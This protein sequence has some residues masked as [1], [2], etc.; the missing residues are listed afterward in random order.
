VSGLEVL[1]FVPTPEQY[2]WTCGGAAPVARIQPGT[3]VRRFTENCLVE[4]GRSERDLRSA[5][6]RI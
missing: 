4:R 3:V 1:S 2:A 5:N 6:S